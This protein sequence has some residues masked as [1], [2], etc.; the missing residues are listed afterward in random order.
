VLTLDGL[1]T[2]VSDFIQ[3]APLKDFLEARKLTFRETAA[4]VA[5]AWSVHPGWVE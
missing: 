5:T 4:V 2:L 1:P 3:G